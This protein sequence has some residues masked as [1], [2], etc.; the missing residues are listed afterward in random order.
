MA[1]IV[2]FGDE[3]LRLAQVRYRGGVGTVLELQDAEYRATAARQTLIAAQVAE[4]EGVVHV[5]FTAGLL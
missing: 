5:R 4:R 1:S 2:T 3:N